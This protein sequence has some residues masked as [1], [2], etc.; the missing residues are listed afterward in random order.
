MWYGWYLWLNQVNLATNLSMPQNFSILE[1]YDQPAR[2]TAP[3][4]RNEY[5]FLVFKTYVISMM[6]N[7]YISNA[8]SSMCSKS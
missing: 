8:V 6:D 2:F 3:N 7:M 5:E 1:K 4:P